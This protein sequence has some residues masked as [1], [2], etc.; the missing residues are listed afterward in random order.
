[1]NGTVNHQAIT[2]FPLQEL[3]QVDA[4]LRACENLSSTLRE[5]QHR[6]VAELDQLTAPQHVPPASRPKIVSRGYEYRGTFF[7]C[8]SSIDTYSNLLR[9]LWNDF[10]GRRE[11]MVA[12]ISSCGTSRNYIASS[13]QNLFLNRPPEWTARHSRLL[14]DGWYLDTNLSNGQKR[15]ILRKA[16]QAVGLRWDGDIKVYWRAQLGN[17]SSN[18]RS[19][20][21]SVSASSSEQEQSPGYVHQG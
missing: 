10:P 17:R 4:A 7:P 16:A 19:P 1:M 12:A 9:S 15:Q 21:P 13:H 5:R 2:S 8:W 11:S 18:D 14:I 20:S 3:E 6:L